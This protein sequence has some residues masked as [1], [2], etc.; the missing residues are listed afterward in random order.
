MINP[1][2]QP[3]P[4]LVSLKDAV[5]RWAG[6]VGLICEPRGVFG[7]LNLVRLNTRVMVIEGEL[8][9]LIERLTGGVKERHSDKPVKKRAVKR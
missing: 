7:E 6:S 8:N 3:K 5:A 1:D 4:R 2:P 9:M